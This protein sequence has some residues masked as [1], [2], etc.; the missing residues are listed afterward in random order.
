MYLNNFDSVAN[1]ILS[2][3][4]SG[5]TWELVEEDYTF[6]RTDSKCQ[7]MRQYVELIYDQSDGQLDDNRVR[8]HRVVFTNL[9]AHPGDSEKGTYRLQRVTAVYEAHADI[10]VGDDLQTLAEDLIKPYVLS[11]FQAEFEPKV[12]GIEE[13]SIQY[14]ETAKRVGGLFQFRFQSP[15]GGDIVEVSYSQTEREAR[16]IDYTHIHGGGEFDAYA[17]PGFAV[18]ENA[19]VRTVITIGSVA[20][21]TRLTNT[22]PGGTAGSVPGRRS[23]N[24]VKQEG[25]NLISATSE[26]T[27]QYIGD[28]DEDQIEITILTEQIVERYNVAPKEGVTTRGGAPLG[29]NGGITPTAP[30]PASATPNST[31][32]ATGQSGNAIGT[33]VFP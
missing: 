32:P 9:S 16:V 14:D 13:S 30:P 27:P 15:R 25:W 28:P 24:E 21:R 19:L 5:V 8:N 17:D 20:A 7:F 31:G 12:F 33:V 6:D 2:T 23:T 26:S 10:E 22:E 18:W 4:G 1:G 11:Q 3:V 29:D